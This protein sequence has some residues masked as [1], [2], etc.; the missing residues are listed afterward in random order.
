MTFDIIFKSGS[1]VKI[2]TSLDLIT[3]VAEVMESGKDQTIYIKSDD[4]ITHL[5]LIRE[6]CYMEQTD[7]T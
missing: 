2:E 5:L 3:M 1:G 4:K 6:I 7:A